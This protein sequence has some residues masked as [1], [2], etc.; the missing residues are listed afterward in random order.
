[1]NNHMG[2]PTLPGFRLTLGFTIFYLLLIV[3]IPLAT[4]PIRTA[5]L[6]W[7]EIWG[8]IVKRAAPSVQVPAALGG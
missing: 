3:I 5:M 7:E 8:T 6:S 2:R 1:M 4:L